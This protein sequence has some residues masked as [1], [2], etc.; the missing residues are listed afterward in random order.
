MDQIETKR[1]WISLLEMR[2]LRQKTWGFA[3]TPRIQPRTIRCRQNMRVDHLEGGGF[4]HQKLGMQ[5][6]KIGQSPI[7][8]DSHL[9]NWMKA[10]VTWGHGK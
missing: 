4:N 6:V 8:S 2:G 3:R 1:S 9:P 5:L 7:L 10:L